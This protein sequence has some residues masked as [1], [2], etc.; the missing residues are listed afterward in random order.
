MLWDS[1]MKS[2]PLAVL[3]PQMLAMAILGG[4]LITFAS[5]RFHKILDQASQNSHCAS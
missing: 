2:N 3:W 4:G 1:F 5:I